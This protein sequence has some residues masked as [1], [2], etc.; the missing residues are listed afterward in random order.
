MTDKPPYCLRCGCPHFGKC[1]RDSDRKP[2]WSVR[3]R[4]GRWRIYDRDVWSD[5]CDTLPEAHTYATANAVA[6]VLYAP[7]GL[8]LLADMR[9]DR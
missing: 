2:R 1:L 4:N 7:G 3:K 9:R 5:T 6:D 8:T